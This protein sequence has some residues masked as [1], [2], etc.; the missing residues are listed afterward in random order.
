MC[1]HRALPRSHRQPQQHPAQ[2]PCKGDGA[3]GWGQRR[4]AQRKLWQLLV[5]VKESVENSFRCERDKMLP[6]E[7]REQRASTAPG[8]REES[9]LT[10]RESTAANP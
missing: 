3:G 9:A 1:P 6:A 2:E 4:Q 8:G 5:N 7:S 10:R